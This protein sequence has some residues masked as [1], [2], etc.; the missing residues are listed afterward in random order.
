[1]IYPLYLT[2]EELAVVTDALL[3]AEQKP[4]TETATN[5]AQTLLR[6]AKY[7]E[8]ADEAERA[9]IDSYRNEER[10]ETE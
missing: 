4:Q 3:K 2:R 9:Y 8:A 1:M 5:K 6:V 7:R 10:Y